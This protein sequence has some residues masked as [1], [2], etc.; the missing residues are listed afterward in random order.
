MLCA[1]SSNNTRRK[2]QQ[3][4]QTYR[5]ENQNAST[6]FAESVP[7][8]NGINYLA[9]RVMEVVWKKLNGGNLLKEMN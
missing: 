9:F 7:T 3:S 8:T 6:L 4:G 5:M 1:N 2:E